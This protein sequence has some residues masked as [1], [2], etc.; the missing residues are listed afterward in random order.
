MEQA[1]RVCFGTYIQAVCIATIISVGLA[2]GMWQLR[3]PI[4]LE[5][6]KNLPMIKMC[7]PTPL[8][9]VCQMSPDFHVDKNLLTKI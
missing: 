7:P 1:P 6:Q 3:T 2:L 9:C 8:N 5:V 4:I